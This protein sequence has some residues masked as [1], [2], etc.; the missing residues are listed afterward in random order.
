M[1]LSK[2]IDGYNCWLRNQTHLLVFVDGL[3]SHNKWFAIHYLWG[4]EL[5]KSFRVHRLKIEIIGWT[6]LISQE[7]SIEWD[8][9]A[10]II[11]WLVPSDLIQIRL[12]V[13]NL[14]VCWLRNTNSWN[15]LLIKYALLINIRL[16]H[17]QSWWIWN[18]DTTIIDSS[19][20]SKTETDPVRL[21]LVL[22]KEWHIYFVNWSWMPWSIDLKSCLNLS[23]SHSFDQLSTF[24]WSRS[25][26]HIIKVSNM[27]KL[28]CLDLSEFSICVDTI[29]WK[30]DTS[31]LSWWKINLT[32][33]SL[34]TLELNMQI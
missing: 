4:S 29:S 17:E 27:I 31:A 13:L 14:H 22:V 30:L 5:V 28:C 19:S 9:I 26:Y 18:W 3:N 20:S 23:V 8:W 10:S 1:T 21:L 32:K 11:C 2:I 24:G 15:V 7:Y 25:V 12:N 34:T 6:I 33:Y 16:I